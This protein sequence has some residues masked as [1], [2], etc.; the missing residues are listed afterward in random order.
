MELMKNNDI[1]IKVSVSG[2]NNSPLR[3]RLKGK[4]RE[5]RRIVNRIREKDH[6]I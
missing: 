5:K 4:E 3:R 1:H 2:C 6:I